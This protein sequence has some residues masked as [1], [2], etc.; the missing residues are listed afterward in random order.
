MKKVYLVGLAI[1]ASVMEAAKKQFPDME[2]VTVDNEQD[3]KKLNK[4][5]EQEPIPYTAR[6]DMGIMPE[7]KVCDMKVH[8]PYPEPH[9]SSKR[10]RKY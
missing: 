9:R 5:F 10:S 1:T 6:P 4:A 2:I 3:V 8:N 7:L